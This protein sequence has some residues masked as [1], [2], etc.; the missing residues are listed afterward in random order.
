LI[1][2]CQTEINRWFGDVSRENV[3]GNGDSPSRELP[4]LV[5]LL[6][7]LVGDMIKLNVVELILKGT[8]DAAIGFHLLVMT[9]RVLH[10]LID[11]ELRVSSN[12]D[13]FDA[14]LDGDSE[15]TEEGLVLFYVV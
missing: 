14:G 8:H 15:A 10:D 11:H 7:V 13:A 2:G 3:Q 9:A 5:G 12:V 6:V 1:R 4:E